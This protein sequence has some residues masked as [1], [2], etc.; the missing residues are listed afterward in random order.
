MTA[1]TTT[2][3]GIPATFQPPMTAA[4]AADVLAESGFDPA[5]ARAMVAGYLDDTSR[6]MGV[7]VHQWGLDDTDLDDIVAHHHEHDDHDTDSDTDGTDGG[8]GR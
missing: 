8:W 6:E 5:Q 7:S 2:T 4:Q 1:W 3:A